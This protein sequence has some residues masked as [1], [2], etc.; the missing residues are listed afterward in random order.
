M[1]IGKRWKIDADS[2]NYILSR[3]V[4]VKANKN[5]PQHYSWRVEGYYPSLK[6]ALKALADF[7]LSDTLLKDLNTIQK[8]QEKV[9]GLIESLDK[10]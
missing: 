7:E 2:L 5:S 8:R 6:S 4:L 10:R 1:N 9:Y 3:R